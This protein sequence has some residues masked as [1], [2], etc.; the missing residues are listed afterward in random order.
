MVSDALAKRLERGVGRPRVRADGC[1]VHL[2]SWQ[3]GR[4]LKTL[5]KSTQR[6][7]SGTGY[8]GIIITN[9]LISVSL[10]FRLCNTLDAVTN[11]IAIVWPEIW[12][13]LVQSNHITF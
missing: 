2:A 1:W 10:F 9:A 6:V 13:S 5:H 11:Q 7:I 4:V 12:Y 3:S 8:V